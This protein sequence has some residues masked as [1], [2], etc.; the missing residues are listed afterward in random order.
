MDYLIRVYENVPR[1][2]LLMVLDNTTPKYII[3]D[4]KRQ[5]VRMVR[6]DYE[7]LAYIKFD[8]KLG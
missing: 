1:E 4:L 2:G 6:D 5:N 3:N 8:E 7:P